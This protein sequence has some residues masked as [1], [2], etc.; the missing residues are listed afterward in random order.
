MKDSN[1]KITAAYPNGTQVHWEAGAYDW[2]NDRKVLFVYG[3]DSEGKEERVYIYVPSTRWVKIKYLRVSV[4]VG[5]NRYFREVT[6]E[7]DSNIPEGEGSFWIG[8]ETPRGR[9]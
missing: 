4:N 7:E 6:R 1:Y 3:E 5:P 2:D 8:R 9:P